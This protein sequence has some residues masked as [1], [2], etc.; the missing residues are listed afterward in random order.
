MNKGVG[1]IHL[2]HYHNKPAM[3]EIY[4]LGTL[5]EFHFLSEVLDFLPDNY[6]GSPFLHCS[7]IV[8]MPS[9]EARSGTFYENKKRPI[10]EAFHIRDGQAFLCE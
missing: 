2:I 10:Q 6:S 3:L 7:F 9:S 4:I 1:Y 5:A 8:L